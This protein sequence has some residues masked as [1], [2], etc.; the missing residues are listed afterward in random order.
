ME[1]YQDKIKEL[2]NK[3]K[4]IIKEKDEEINKI[5]SHVSERLFLCL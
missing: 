2:L 3:E 4:Q 5:I 1:N